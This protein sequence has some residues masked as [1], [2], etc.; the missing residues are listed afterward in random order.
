MATAPSL[1][2]SKDGPEVEQLKHFVPK[3]MWS[4]NLHSTFYPN[5]FHPKPGLLSVSSARRILE[6]MTHMEY[7]IHI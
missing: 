3:T 4:T 5:Q 1:S 2:T 7:E 6:S